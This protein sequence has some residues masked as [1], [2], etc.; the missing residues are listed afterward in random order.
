MKN[1]LRLHPLCFLGQSLVILWLTFTPFISAAATLTVTNG[2]DNGPGSLRNALATASNNDLIVF[3]SNVSTVTLTSG[4]LLIEKSVHINGGTSGVTITRSGDIQFRIF[5]VESA[6]EQSPVTAFLTLLTISNGNHPTQGGGIQ[7]SATLTLNQCRITGNTALQGGGIQNDGVITLNSCTIDN[8]TVSSTGAGFISFGTSNTLTNCTISNNVASGGGGGLNIQFGDL[9]MTHC[10]IAYNQASEGGG[11]F[12]A[13]NSTIVLTNTILANNPATNIYGTVSNTSS[14]NI[15][16]STPSTSGGMSNGVNG[17]IL[18][19]SPLL[20]PLDTY[21]YYTPTHPLLPGSPAINAGTNTSINT[22]QRGISRP[23]QSGVDIGAFESQGFTMFIS[24]GNN[25]SANLS[26]AFT[27]PLIVTVTSSYS[28]PVKDGKVTFT[29]PA[30]GAKATITTTMATINDQGLATSGTVSANNVG[31]TYTVTTESNGVTSPTSFTLTNICTEPS[32][33]I[34]P[35]ST[36]VCAGSKATFNVTATGSLLTYVWKKNDQ[37]LSTNST[38]NTPLLTLS[39]SG[40]EYSVVVSGACGTSLTASATVTV[41][42]ASIITSPSNQL[43]CPHNSATFSVSATGTNLGYQWR[44]GGTDIP[45]ATDHNYTIPNVSITDAGSYDVIVSSTGCTSATSSAATLTLLSAA[46]MTPDMP[47]WGGRLNEGQFQLGVGLWN[48]SEGPMFAFDGTASKSLIRTTSNAGFIFTPSTCEGNGRIINQMRIYTANDYPDRDP[49]SYAIYGTNNTFNGSGPFDTSV[50]TLISSGDLNLPLDRNINSLNDAYSQ[51]VSFTNTTPYK[52]YM[53]I[54]PSIQ[55]SSTVISTQ[56]AEVKFYPEN[57]QPSFV[58]SSV[59]NTQGKTIVSSLGTVTSG[60]DQMPETLSISIS[61]DGTN[62]GP[63]ATSNG[64]TISNI[65]IAPTGIVDASIATLCDATDATFTVK[66]TNALNQSQ[67]TSLSVSTHTNPSPTLSYADISIEAGT[68]T[69]NSPSVATDNGSILT[70]EIQ[71]SGTYSGSVSVNNSG[72]VSFNNVQPTGNH[73]II[74]RASDDCGA[75]TDASFNINISTPVARH[76]RSISSNHWNNLATW[77]TS[78]DGIEWEAALNAPTANYANTITIRSPHIVTVSASVDADE[79]SI[80]NGGTLIVN[81]GIS[82][83]IN[84]GTGVDVSVAGLLAIAGT[85][86]NNGQVQINGTLQI[87]QEGTLSNAPTYAI[88]SLLKYNTAGS[89]ARGN[90]WTPNA[91]SGTGYPFDVQLSN[92][93]ALDLSNSSTSSLFQLAGNLIID[94]GSTLSMGAMTQ[95]LIILGNLIY[96]GTLVFSSGIGGDLK[97]WGDLSQQNSGTLTFNG[98]TIYFEGSSTQNISSSTGSLTFPHLTINKG[99]GTVNLN[100]NLNINGDGGGSSLIFNTESSTLTI[101]SNTLT[102]GG[103]LPTPPLNSGII[104]SSTSNLIL[105]DGDTTGDMGSIRFVADHQLLGNLTINRTTSTGN[106]TLLSPLEISDVLALTSGTITSGDNILESSATGS[107]SRTQGYVIGNLQKTFSTSAPFTLPVG[108]PN[109]YSPVSILFLSGPGTLMARAIQSKHPNIIGPN[110]L[111]RYW[112]ITGSSI[113][114]NLAFYYLP[115]DV[116]GTPSNYRIVQ[117][118]NGF[119]PPISFFHDLSNRIGYINGVSNFSDFTFAELPSVFPEIGIKS[120]NTPIANGSGTFSTPNNTFFGSVEIGTTTSR[121]YTIFNTGAPNLNLTGTPKVTLLG[122]PEF[123][124]IT[125]PN[126]PV[127]PGD[128]TSFSIQFEPTTVG[129]R[130]TLVSIANDDTDENPYS[131]SIKAT[132]KTCTLPTISS[133]N[134]T[135]PTCATNTGTAVVNASGTGTLE[136]SKDGT[137]WQESNTFT[138]L[139][140]GNYTFQ[141]RLQ[142]S[143]TCSASSQQQTINPVPNAPTIS[144]VN[145]TQPTCATNT[146]T[147]VVNASGTGTLEYSK[148]ATNWQESNTFSGLAPENYTFQVRLQNNTSCSNSSAQQ[149]VN[150]VPN[151]PTISSVNLTQPTCATNTGTAVVNASGTGTLE[152]S[153]DGTNWQESNTFSGLAPGNYTFQARLQNNTSCS[154]SSAQQTI[155]SVP[156]APTI[157]S[158]NLTQPTCATNTG[159]ALVNASGTGTLEY[160]K[161]ATNWQESNTFSGLAPGN[162]TFQ[163]RLQ[164]STTCS[165]SFQQQTINAVPNAPTISSVN[166][167]QPT[168]ATNTGTAVVNASGTGTLEYSKDGTNWQESNTFTNLT[169]G[170]YTFQVRL[171]NSTTCSAS[172]QQQTINPVPNAPTISSVNLTQPTCATNTG[173]AVVNASGTGTLEYSKDGTNWQESNTFSGLAPGNYTFQVRLQNNTSCSNSSA[174]QTVNP[175]PNAPT[176]SSVNLTQPTCATNTGTAVVNASGT[177]TLEYSK[178]ATNWQESNTFTNLPAGNYTFQVRLQNSMTCSASSQQQTINAVPNAPTIS[179]VNLTQPT[180]ATNT[181]TALVNASGTGTL[182]YSKDGTNWQES[183]TFNNLASGNYTFQVRLQNN[184]SCSNSSAQQTI[185]A[186]PNA[187]TIS[188]VNLTQ[189]TCATNTAT[190]LVNA[191]GTGTLEYSK[192]ATNWQESNTFSGLAP[193]NYTFQVRLQNNTSCSN[194]SAQQ[195]INAVPNAPTISSVNL[196]QPTCATNTGTA[197]VN[198]SGTGTLEYSKDATNWQESNTFSGLA[199][200]NYTFQVRLQNN[201]SCSNSSAQQTINAVPNA[202]TISSVNL[203]QPTCTTNTGTAVVNASGT[204]TLEYSKDATNWQESNTFTNLP[205]GN[206]TFQVRLQNSMTCSASSQQQTINPV[207][208]APTIS[209]VNLTQPTCATNTGTALVNAS[210]TGTLEYSKDAT[211]WQESNT[212]SGLTAGNYTFQVRLQNNT[213]CSASSQQQTINPV[214]NAPTISSVNLTQPTC[215]TN[216]GTAVINASGTGTLEYSKD[217]TNWQESNTFNSLAPGNYTFQVRLQN[218]TSCSNSSAQQTINP[219]PNAPTISS[220][221]LTQPT[222]ATN[223]GTALVNA[224]GTGTL[225]YSKDGTNWQESNTF[226][227][228]PAGNYTFQV[229]LQNSTTCSASSQQQTINAVPNAPTISSVNLTQPTCATNTGT[230]LVNA[231]GTGTLEYS[232]DATNWQESNTFSGLTA[233]NYTFQVRLQNNTSCS[234]SS[235]QQTINAV[236]NAP[237]I[238]S[239]NLTQPTCDTNTGTAVV[240]ASGT[241]ILEY[242]KDGTN[243]QESN[244]FNTL[245]A[246]NYTFQVRLQNNTTCS[247]SSQQQTINAVPNAPTISSVN[248]TQPTCATNTG[249]AVVNASGTGTLEYSKDGTNWQE[250]NTFSNLAAGN[251]TFQVRLQNNITCSASSQQQTINATPTSLTV[252]NLQGGATLCANS[253]G[254]TPAAAIVLNGSQVGVIYQLKKDNQNFREP[255]SGTGSNLIFSNITEAGTYTVEAFVEGRACLTNM[256]GTATIYLGQSPNVFALTGGGSYCNGGSGVAIGLSGSQEGFVYQ[257]RRSNTNIGT[258]ISGTGN[259]I[260]FGNQTTAGSYTVVATQATSSC[261]RNMSGSKTVT[262]TNCNARVANKENSPIESTEIKDWAT[263]APNPV[264]NSFATVLIKG[265]ANQ[266]IQWK[267]IDLKGNILKQNT[268]EITSLHHRQEIPLQNTPIGTYFLKFNT[269]V[270]SITLKIVKVD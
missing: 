70:Y 77:E 98:R 174:Q 261:N 175:V 124:V 40:D 34:P 48:S 85:I 29:A 129:D 212:F 90:E 50:F 120:K 189:P 251:Y 37:T 241:G 131:F 3:A 186:V 192:D 205:A 193:G 253:S 87:N 13:N 132:G 240:N 62:F 190:A 170:N 165:A 59:S 89:F 86:I 83:T 5:N 218:N 207:P 237:T 236:P 52:S 184:T 91:I 58:V 195:T 187:P 255:I 44:K 27:H 43:V 84:D 2:N 145:L 231:S 269:D 116:V 64:V 161:D 215:A 30:S 41:N 252:F 162:Y 69:T 227:N 159:T 265:Q 31:G 220:V 180:C 39:N 183:N 169:A 55:N 107:I 68:A 167:T 28:E 243:W 66:V 137:N 249:T 1:S 47:F 121:L 225:E 142:N 232:K 103:F 21:G 238:S 105:N 150:P 194:S 266:T 182:E 76:Y 244:T 54:F 179:S 19:T 81:N 18:S 24:E 73:I 15:L 138:N 93:T 109:G 104:G 71:S 100:T 152:Y 61:S 56:I 264:V 75:Y 228:L 92:N 200:G 51:L 199:P 80:A 260:S 94:H 143:T 22:D 10:T 141:V 230:A 114:A 197:L 38:Y 202:P 130:T 17:N 221:N 99:G 4:E 78:I 106:I 133:V 224:S 16:S 185:N 164:N 118:N 262:I 226:T 239:V 201:T 216:T 181:G 151:A 97:L 7:N 88:G 122:D 149:T 245:A 20:A 250:S 147:A 219:V 154:N 45:N 166:L 217:A 156:N 209:S 96:S 113:T 208:N 25:Q 223:T 79:V 112:H 53:L 229:R 153:K 60:T 14:H 256:N 268:F 26:T 177:G 233:G 178:D 270:R 235:Q 267:L 65:A 160:A 168:C 158:V 247:T 42:G 8:N 263:I 191:S 63:S 203:T 148:D 119:I 214:P 198:A 144:S 127:S 211:N 206:Y 35:A 172:S 222:C 140:A 11:I 6:S 95:P 32:I 125:Q 49:A 123:S 126:S 234:A 173:T 9:S 135:Q 136:Y 196:T 258:P 139:T 36:T 176:I 46:V 210:G 248:L 134:L 57:F 157:S 110:A 213:S 155:N 74:I 101:N 246:G 117:Y 12:I 67:T 204:G 163:V 128:S 111:N 146:G 102:L 108:T 23:H 259:A 33:T 257:L 254:N 72:V 171:Q 82:L 242:S 188:S 115:T